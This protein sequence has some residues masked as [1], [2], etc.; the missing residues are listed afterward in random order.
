MI[1]LNVTGLHAPIRKYGV[2]DWIMKQ[3]PNYAACVIPTLRWRTD[4]L[5]V[6]EQIK[7]YLANGNDEKAGKL[8][9]YQTKMDFKTKAT[10]KDE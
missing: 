9:K 7:V 10:K 8:T 5:K 3:K 6:R 4:R 2:A 1:T